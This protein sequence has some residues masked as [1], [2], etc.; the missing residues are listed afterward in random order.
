MRSF[1]WAITIFS[2]A[3]RLTLVLFTDLGVDEAY[4]WTYLHPVS[5]SYFDHPLMVAIWQW[6]SSTIFQCETEWVL[7]WTF[8]MTG[9]VNVLLCYQV[10]SRI[11][12]PNS[13]RWITIAYQASPY[14]SLLTGAMVLPDGPLIFFILI[15]LYAFVLIYQTDQLKNSFFLIG[16]SLGLGFLSK[17]QMVFFTLGFF[18]YSLIYK[19]IWWTQCTFY[20]NALIIVASLVPVIIWNLDHEFVQWSFHSRRVNPVGHPLSME[21][22]GRELAGEVF[23]Q[24]PILYGLILYAVLFHGAKSVV[25]R[26]LKIA[27]LLFSIPLYITGLGFSLFNPTLPHWTGPAFIPLLL[28]GIPAVFKPHE[29][30]AIGLI[31]TSWILFISFFCLAITEL[32][33]GLFSNRLALK[34]PKYLGKGDITQD[35]FGWEQLHAKSKDFMKDALLICS[36]KWWSAQYDYYLSRQENIPFAALG[37]LSDVHQYGIPPPPALTLPGTKLVYITSSNHY[38]PYSQYANLESLH[39]ADTL[40]IPIIRSKDTVRQHYLYIFQ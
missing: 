4:Y 18:V 21:F 33:L 23:Y 40:I 13:A 22:F 29:K 31:T 25:R 30:V 5:I 14:F 1:F 9:T 39:C 34:N 37:S 27:L 28:I 8:F 24:N 12:D 16:L 3:M 6:I 32:N 38:V 10:S 7:R 36:S 20:L 35:M 26:P 11:T 19:R 15:F 17:Y 2:V